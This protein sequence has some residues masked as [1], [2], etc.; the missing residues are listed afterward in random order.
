[1]ENNLVFPDEIKP[2]ALGALADLRTKVLRGTQVGMA[3]R[4]L[5]EL[6]F[7]DLAAAIQVGVAPAARSRFDLTEI[8]FRDLLE[9]DGRTSDSDNS[10]WNAAYKQVDDALRTIANRLDQA[11]FDRSPASRNGKQTAFGSAAEPFHVD[12]VSWVLR[13]SG[14]LHESSSDDK[15]ANIRLVP[16][17]IEGHQSNFRPIAAPLAE[18]PP[19]SGNDDQRRQITSFLEA[20]PPSIRRLD[21]VGAPH[22]LRPVPVTFSGRDALLAD[23]TWWRSTAA[24][25]SSTGGAFI[26]R[27]GAS[28]C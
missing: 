23:A 27:W 11:N 5:G 25:C 19:V 6:L 16:Q 28:K 21:D 3:P 24:P 10:T 17:I 7:S 20:L 12:S 14:P 4:W 8:R 18:K 1:M 9:K 22:E 2:H 15:R 13:V 26:P